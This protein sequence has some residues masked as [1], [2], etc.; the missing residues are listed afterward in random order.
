MNFNYYKKEKIRENHRCYSSGGSALR[1]MPSM[2]MFP[3]G[4]AL[5]S[6]S[7]SSFLSRCTWPTVPSPTFP[8]SAADAASPPPPPERSSGRPFASA[9][10]SPSPLAARSAGASYAAAMAP[11]LAAAVELS[12]YLM[13]LLRWPV[14]SRCTP[15]FLSVANESPQSR[16]KCVVSF[17]FFILSSRLTRRFCRAIAG[18]VYDRNI[19][20]RRFTGG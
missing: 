20:I 19:Y 13:G 11:T 16:H 7:T 9:D 17:P 2:L 15:S 3:G 10:P 12:A 8:P 6:I 18:G 14:V 5:R 4:S 1:S